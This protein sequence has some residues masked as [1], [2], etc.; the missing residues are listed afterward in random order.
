MQTERQDVACLHFEGGSG[1]GSAI[2]CLLN[3]L[4]LVLVL[5]A[6]AKRGPLQ[7]GGANLAAKEQA[8]QFAACE[9][10]SSRFRRAQAKGGKQAAAKGGC[11][12]WFWFAL[13]VHTI[14]QQP[15]PQCGA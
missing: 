12:T 10:V 5:R 4:V 8:L 3:T 6:Q 1:G 7:R 15:R 9:G 11:K 13:F 14:S 2:A